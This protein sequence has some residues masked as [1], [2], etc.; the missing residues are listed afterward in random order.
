MAVVASSVDDRGHRPRRKNT[1]P[2][3][4]ETKSRAGRR[5]IGLP[6]QLVELLHEHREK[7]ERERIAARQMWHDGD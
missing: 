1:R 2:E 3:T 5:S 6:P 4:A 7:Q